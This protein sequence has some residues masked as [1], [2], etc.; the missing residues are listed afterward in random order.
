MFFCSQVQPMI[1][2]SS[3][4]FDV[5]KFAGD[6]SIVDNGRNSWKIGMKSG[7]LSGYVFVSE[8]L[9]RKVGSKISVL[10]K[11]GTDSFVELGFIQNLEHPSEQSGNDMV[12][13]T[14]GPTVS[15]VYNPNEDT[16]YAPIDPTTEIDLYCELIFKSSGTILR[17]NGENIYNASSDTAEQ[18]YAYIGSGDN[19]EYVEFDNLRVVRN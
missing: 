13:V 6:A 1:V 16:I 4:A 19:N 18:Y 7:S 2:K 3:G 8:A 17:I 14:L 9:K 11:A 10:I 5:T 12:A 15:A